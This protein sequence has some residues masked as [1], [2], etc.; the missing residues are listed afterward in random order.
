MMIMGTGGSTRETRDSN[1]MK[2]RLRFVEVTGIPCAV[3][4]SGVVKRFFFSG[5][6]VST[7]ET[8][9]DLSLNLEVGKRETNCRVDCG[10]GSLTAHDGL[11]R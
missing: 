5:V 4:N 7:F 10:R 8:L 3:Y 9:S 1:F 2:Q 6:A 11:S